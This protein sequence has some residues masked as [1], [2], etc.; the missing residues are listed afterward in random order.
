M[1][2][3]DDSPYPYFDNTYRRTTQPPCPEE[4]LILCLH[5][6]CLSENGKCLSRIK[7]GVR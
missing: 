5:G 4:S 1:K 2:Y 6:K 3:S 7:C